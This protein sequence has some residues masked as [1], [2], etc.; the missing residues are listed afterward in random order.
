MNNDIF[1]R[2]NENQIKAVK[3]TEGRIRVVAGAGSGK[4]RVLANR[5]A[6][7]VDEIGID[8][9]NI[10]CLTFTNKAAQEMK[11][12]IRKMVNV[13]NTNDFICTIHGFCVKILR[14]DIY[15]LGFPS[16]FM[17]IDEDDS[18]RLAKQVFEEFNISKSESTVQ[19]FL[20]RVS[21]FKMQ[22]DINDGHR[23]YMD[24]MLPGCDEEKYKANE[25]AAY[26]RLQLKY[27]AVDFQDIIYFALHLL[28]NFP[29]VLEYWQNEINYLQV[30]EVQ[31]CSMTDWKL[32]ELLCGK[33][34][35]LFVVGDPD[36]AIYEWRG[37]KPDA[38]VNFRADE[39]IILN[40]NYRS[41]SNILDVANS[42]IRNNENRVKKN[43]YTQKQDS[44]IT[45]HHHAKS[46]KAE[47]EWIANQI[48][49]T[50]EKGGKAS[51]FA[52]LYRASYQSRFVEQALMQKSINYVIWGG[53][54]FF[55][56]LEIK[57]RYLVSILF[58]NIRLPNL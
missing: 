17:I 31:D 41:T 44:C 9:A 57:H 45:I 25:M 40:R 38:F 52:I 29:D 6:Y 37:A 14:R 10:V 20:D 22:L 19:K 15:R 3:A 8:P 35:N 56:R 39:T 5:Y 33:Y 13:G 55:E 34:Q 46:E 42:I 49:K 51:D 48:A 36:Q 4:T 2:L 43:L 18:K 24:Y 53:I 54:R 21:G 16:N 26:L 23:I 47:G 1:G 12:R 28:E 30:D 27:F 32:L 7:L 50:I 11:T 58:K